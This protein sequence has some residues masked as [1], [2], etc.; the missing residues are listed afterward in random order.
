M[1]KVQVETIFLCFTTGS[2][3]YL[4]QIIK[5][6]RISSCNWSLPW[7]K[8]LCSLIGQ[9]VETESLDTAVC[10]LIGSGFSA[11]NMQ[12]Y[13]SLYHNKHSLFQG[14]WLFCTIFLRFVLNK[15]TEYFHDITLKICLIRII[16]Q[17][18]FT[19][20]DLYLVYVIISLKT[21]PFS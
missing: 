8:G 12:N 18:K 17:I 20:S 6:F 10:I 3:C 9:M 21:G 4:L 13:T 16:Q 14:W 2:I 7:L 1:H 15:K 11:I 19:V 5:L